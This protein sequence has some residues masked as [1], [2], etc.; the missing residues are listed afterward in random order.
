VQ[1]VDEHRAELAT[2]ALKTWG[3]PRQIRQIAEEATE[4]SLAAQHLGNRTNGDDW[5][6]FIA[7]YADMEI[8]MAQAKKILDGHGALGRKRL[9]QARAKA[10]AKLVRHLDKADAERAGS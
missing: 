9:Y 7:E 6:A 1:T 2:R 10:M 4:L 5:L 8:M 3:I